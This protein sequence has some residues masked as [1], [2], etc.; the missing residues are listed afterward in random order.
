MGAGLVCGGGGEEG[1]EVACVRWQKGPG[2]R[3]RPRAC[4]GGREGEHGVVHAR[5]GGRE[6]GRGFAYARSPNG[7]KKGAG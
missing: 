4:D 1:C 5:V 2:E 7:G 3:G 6:H